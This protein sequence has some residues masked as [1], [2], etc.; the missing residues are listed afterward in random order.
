MATLQKLG[1]QAQCP[2][3]AEELKIGRA[4]DND[5][6]IEDDSVSGYHAIVTTKS[7]PGPGCSGPYTIND[8]KS[9]NKT[10]VNNKEIS[11][12]ELVDGD[13][14]RLGRI[15]LKY[16][17]KEYFEPQEELDKT[18]ELKKS[19]IPNFLFMK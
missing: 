15:R 19:K 3:N 6:I 17:T 2:I 11:S 14:I 10:F 13:I 5:I 4:P 18:I 1:D 8:L 7:P 12:Q 16:S 9:T